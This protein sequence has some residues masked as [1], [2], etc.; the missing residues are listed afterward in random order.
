VCAIAREGGCDA[1]TGESP[2]Q[3]AGRARAAKARSRALLLLCL[4]A[5]APRNP[6][7]PCCTRKHG[8]N[9]FVKL[10]DCMVALTGRFPFRQGLLQQ[11]NASSTPPFKKMGISRTTW[12][13]DTTPNAPRL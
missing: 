2:A 9:V 5:I 11:K 3:K 7:V 1:G 6:I 13:A 4:L 10:L 8:F 12:L